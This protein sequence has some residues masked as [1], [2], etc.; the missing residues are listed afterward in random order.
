MF[1]LFGQEAVEGDYVI[2]EHHSYSMRGPGSP[3]FVPAIVHGKKAYAPY[4]T[5]LSNGEGFK[6]V[7]KEM[8]IVKI[9]KEVAL[10]YFEE[11]KI[12]GKNIDFDNEI[13][14]NIDAKRV[15]DIPGTWIDHKEV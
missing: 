15:A 14:T 7:R 9:P 4:I 13:K 2:C 1:T 3:N 5:R 10:K 12:D 8:A 11:N 6:W